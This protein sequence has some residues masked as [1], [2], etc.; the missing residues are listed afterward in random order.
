MKMAGSTTSQPNQPHNDR[1]SR[2]LRRAQPFSVKIT[3]LPW[4]RGR[5]EGIPYT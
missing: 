1:T 2:L 3:P 5:G 4:E